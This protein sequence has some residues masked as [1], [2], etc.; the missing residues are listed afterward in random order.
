MTVDVSLVNNSTNALDW[1]KLNW[2]GPYVPGG[3]LSPGT[4]STAMAV[5]WPDLPSAKLTFIDKRTR[6]P[7]EIEIS[8]RQITQDVRSGKGHRV[9]IRILSYDKAEVVCEGGTH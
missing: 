9:V 1:V 7:Y 6:A 5:E 3:I 2:Q 4:S 8:L